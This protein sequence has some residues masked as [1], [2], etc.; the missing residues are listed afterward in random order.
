VCI[1]A[2]VNVEWLDGG[3]TLGTDARQSDDDFGLETIISGDAVIQRHAEEGENEDCRRGYLLYGTLGTLNDRDGEPEGSCFD[4]YEP[5]LDDD[6]TNG[7]DK[8][9]FPT[10]IL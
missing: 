7:T 8:Y 6:P 1:S 4:R 3:N 5:M 9:I 10:E 2:E